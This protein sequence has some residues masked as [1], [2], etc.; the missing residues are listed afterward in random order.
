MKKILLIGSKGKYKIYKD[1][2][3][4]VMK[5]KVILFDPLLRRNNKKKRSFNQIS[6]NLKN[7]KT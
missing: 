3:E 7:S 1:I 6:E 5:K 4:T 2:I